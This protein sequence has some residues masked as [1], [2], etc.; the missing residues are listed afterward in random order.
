MSYAYLDQ[1]S[2][3]HIVDRKEDAEQ[4]ASGRIVE[5]GIPN[6]GGYPE[7]DGKHVIV[8]VKDEK[9]KVNG[10]EYPLDTNFLKKYPQIA[11]LLQDLK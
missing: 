1:Y 7:A 4:Y 10:V 8:Y 11:D 6:G 5:T 2:I 3:L 9:Y